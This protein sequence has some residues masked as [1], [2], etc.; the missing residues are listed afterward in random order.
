M[1]N[2]VIYLVEYIKEYMLIPGRIENI[3]L[4]IDF[5]ELGVFNAPYSLFKNVAE[6]L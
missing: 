1:T 4:V 6:L 3:N 5:K 2:T